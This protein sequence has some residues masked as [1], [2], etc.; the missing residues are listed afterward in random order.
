MSGF[1]AR[2]LSQFYLHVPMAGHSKRSKVKRFK[3]GIDVKRGK[4]LTAD[5]V[6]NDRTFRLPVRTLQH[7][8]GNNSNENETD[9]LDQYVI[10]GIYS[11]EA[12]TSSS[13]KRWSDPAQV[14]AAGDRIR[15]VSGHAAN[16]APR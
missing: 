10:G 8:C 13:T 2:R 15:W 7:Q 11:R 1:L 12:V 4:I 14:F 6:R 16:T 3:G 5:H 9:N